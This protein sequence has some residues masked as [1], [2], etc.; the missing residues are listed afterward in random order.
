MCRGGK[1]KRGERAH[2]MLSQWLLPPG[3]TQCTYASGKKF[4][5]DPAG[6]SFQSLIQVQTK[7]KEWY[8]GHREEKSGAVKLDM[9][10]I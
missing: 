2:R 6:N 4:Y 3:W 1:G 5:K 9:R 10:R 8:A 7:N